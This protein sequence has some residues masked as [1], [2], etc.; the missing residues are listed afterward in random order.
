[1][2]SETVD[3][4]LAGARLRAA[5]RVDLGAIEANVRR[6]SEIVGP[7][8]VMAVVKAD[9]YGHGLLASAHAAQAGGADWL[10]VAFVEEALALRAAGVEGRLMCWLA[11]PGE[12]LTKAVL[13]DV[14]LSAS[15]AWMVDEIA[16]AA[17]Q[18]GKE[19]R[20]HLKVDTGLSRAGAAPADWPLLV[21]A[22]LRAQ[23]RGLVRVVGV[24]SHLAHGDDPQNPAM[25]AQ[26][27][28]FNDAL[29]I[30]KRAG[31]TPDVRHLANSGGGLHRPDAR[32]DLVR[33]GI[34][35]YG[36]TPAP[37]VARPR[38]LGLR[39]AMTLTARLALTKSVPAGVGV[40]YGHRYHTPE[41][42]TLGL[43]PLGY[44]DGVP[45][46]AG[47][48]VEVLVRGAGKSARRTIAGT[49]CMDQFVVDLGAVNDGA[50]MAGDEVV[51]FGPGDDG[52]PT[53]EDWAAALGTISYEVVT[54]I[55]PRVPRVYTK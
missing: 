25:D 39:P 40:S 2:S 33:A 11:A 5:A 30:A 48:T 10:G 45:R 26:L 50:F 1:M 15:A 4:A 13:A 12:Q 9:G 41:A 20:V 16:A 21:D 3:P 18:A 49:V 53:A 35:V 22:A 19:A 6:I 31:V 29:E 7:S 42:T 8:Q 28:E 32:F 17:M 38:D 52:E 55:G 43:V 37:N 54:R 44:A 47:N 36:L 27:R 51:L 46:A 24:W 14:D 23:G 34:A